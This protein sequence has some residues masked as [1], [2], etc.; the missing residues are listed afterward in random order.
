VSGA[1]GIRDLYLKFTGSSGFLF[2][3]NWWRF[4]PTYLDAE[5]NR[6]GR[7]QCGDEIKARILSGSPRL[8]RLEFIQKDRPETITITLLDMTGR[9]MATLFTGQTQG[10]TVTCAIDRDK[11]GPGV[12][13]VRVARGKKVSH[14]RLQLP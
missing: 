8:L 2:N 1:S 10:P 4:T 3:F 7:L 9:A 5:M 11:A 13:C 6:A 14:L 12:Y